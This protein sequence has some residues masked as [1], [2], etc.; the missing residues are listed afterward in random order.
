MRV[1]IWQ[2][3]TILS[4]CLGYI[5]FQKELTEA[6]PARNNYLDAQWN[7]KLAEH[8]TRPWSERRGIE[9]IDRNAEVVLVKVPLNVLSDI[10]AA[11]AIESKRDV[12][13]SE[14]E[15]LGSFVFAYQL[16]G[17]DW[18]IISPDM[19]SD[20]SVLH[21]TEL[22]KL[23]Q[24]LGQPAIKLIVSDTGCCISYELFEGGE[25]IEY[26]SGSE[27][28]E[29]PEDDEHS[30]KAQRYIL[31]PDPD[32]NPEAQQTAY[33]WS[34]R[35]QITAEEIGSIW[36]FTD[37]FL[38]EHDAF[39]PAIDSSNLLGEYLLKPGDCYRVRNLQFTLVLGAEGEITSVPE[40]VRVDYF[41]FAN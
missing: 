9:S 34:L 7:L 4:L 41:R 1:I 16:V 6:I 17:H 20:L 8:F 32:D 12:I 2:I 26:F 15:V 11:K 37:K 30:L 33:F 25:L 38:C 28:D 10:L 35:R 39:D 29:S 22:A 40:L 14:I 36:S 5:N 13:G 18:S 23:S 21:S 31:S 19:S 24:H 3:V 27:Y